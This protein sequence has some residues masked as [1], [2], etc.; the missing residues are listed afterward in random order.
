MLP[1]EVQVELQ[2]AVAFLHLVALLDKGAEALSPEGHGVDAHMDK[3]LH[4]VLQLQA[5]GVVGVKDKADGGVAGGGDH[6]LAGDDGGAVAIIFS[7]KA[8]RE[9]AVTGADSPWKGLR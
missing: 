1:D 5:D 6:T 4:A 9:R 7:A 3:H 8:G 2:Q